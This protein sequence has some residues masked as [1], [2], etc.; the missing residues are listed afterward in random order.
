MRSMKRTN[1]LAA[2]LLVGA[3]VLVAG[4]CAQEVG[5]IDRTGPNK[6][7]KEDFQG[8]QWYF[9]QTV[10]DVPHTNAFFFTGL[11]TGSEKLRW[12]ITEDALIGY[13]SYE[14]TPGADPGAVTNDIDGT[15]VAEGHGEGINPDEYKGSPVVAYPISS[16]FDVQRAYNAQTGEQSNVLEENSSD[17]YWDER[18]YMRV[19]WAGNLLTNINF[20]DSDSLIQHQYFLGDEFADDD[21]AKPTINMEYGEDGKLNYL[22][23]RTKA[24]IV[25]S[26][27]CYFFY[28]ADCG[29]T[30]VEIVS[31]FKKAP[32]Q[33]TYEMVQYDDADMAKFGYFRT[34]RA[35]YDRRRGLRREG[36]IFLPN[37]HNIWE[38]AYDANGDLIPLAQRN[39]KTVVYY[40]NKHM[41]EDLWEYN[42]GTADSWD[43]AFR[44]AVAAA[45]GVDPD[46][47]QRMFAICHNPVKA[48]D[49]P[50]CG[51][52][53][54]EVATGDLRYNHVY[55]VPD[56]QLQGPLG[57]GPSAADPET[58][59]IISG[60]AYVYGAAVDRYAATAL[61]VVKLAIACETQVDGAGADVVKDPA[62]CQAMLDEIKVGDD[63]R[64]E[65]IGRVNSQI[66]PRS[67]LTAKHPELNLKALPTDAMEVFKP[68]QRIRYE[69]FKRNPMPYD[70]GFEKRRVDIVR[71]KGY[72]LMMFNQDDVRRLTGGQYDDIGQVPD[73][74]L[75]EI[76]PANWMTASKVRGLTE[77]RINHYARNNVLHEDFFDDV[78]I[79]LAL[80]L[81]NEAK[82]Q[83]EAQREDF[84]YQRLRG[85]IYKAVME[86][87]IGH[88]LG[89]R[90][91]FQGSYDSLN[92]FDE[93]WKL[94][95]ESLELVEAQHEA[96]ADGN[97]DAQASHEAW[98]EAGRPALWS[99]GDVY[100]L[101]A[102]TPNQ[103]A[104]RV[105]NA[106][107]SVEQLTGGMREYQY[108]SIMDY[109]LQFNT[110]IQGLGRYDEAAIIYAYTT[111][112]DGQMNDAG[113]PRVDKGYVEAFAPEAFAEA[114]L[115]DAGRP[116]V[117]DIIRDFDDRIS[118]AYTKL[119]EGYHYM[120]IADR[121]GNVENFS[122][123]ELVKYDVIK[124][125][126]AAG[127]INRPVEVPYMF[128]TDDWVGV[129]SSCHRWDHGADPYEQ[130]YLVAQ[131]YRNYYVFNNFSRDSLNFDPF[132]LVSRT[133]SRVLYYMNN[134][135]Q[136]VF[137]GG[138][139]NNQAF[140]YRWLGAHA[141]LNLVSEIMTMP[142]YGN[143][144]IPKAR[145][146]AT[147]L[148]PNSG[149]CEMGGYRVDV[150]VD[151][152]ND[153][154]LDSMELRDTFYVCSSEEIDLREQINDD[155]T[156]DGVGCALATV[157]N[158][159][160]DMANCQTGGIQIDYGTD[161]NG[162]GELGEDE[163]DVSSTTCNAEMLVQ[164]GWEADC[165]ESDVD[166]V[167]EKGEG[168][169][170][171]SRFDYDRGYNYYNYPTEAGHFYDYLAAVLSMTDTS[172][173]VRGVDVDTDLLSYS[174]P[175]HLLFSGEVNSLFNSLWLQDTQ[176]HGPR[177]VT[178]GANAGQ[179]VPRA[180]VNV[181]L[182][183]GLPMNPE[184]GEVVDSND[185]FA[186][187]MDNS[188]SLTVRP[189]VSYG[190]RFYALLYGMAFFSSNLDLTF[191]DNNK[192]FRVG[193]GEQ[194]QPGDG[195]NTISCED[196]ISG[197]TYAALTNTGS[198]NKS[199]AEIMVERCVMFADEYRTARARLDFN[200]LASVENDLVN[201]VGYMNLMR[202]FYSDFG[203]L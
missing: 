111:G 25:P 33:R 105:V 23:F 15:D 178:T 103:R 12:E 174:I 17:R 127:D 69:S 18:D 149:N 99:V 143:Y 160:A 4:G 167:I 196:P 20:F 106:D 77:A 187:G 108:S 53:G 81:A 124:E 3:S 146:V 97:D 134:I 198:L 29:P 176:K 202:S 32:E 135:Y 114:R 194:I 140:F 52:E 47:V 24:I 26:N 89:L 189:Y 107:G 83:P 79:G 163:I 57:Y 54:L 177:I 85:L 28:E 152:D 200:R 117:A 183:S 96:L 157:T 197:V 199:A 170:P 168:R 91:N 122:K 39:P 16:H 169:Y 70:P 7:K 179:L 136:G 130:S 95:K 144:T 37:R 195:F 64:M 151:V 10:A 161:L 92:Y 67:E 86:H 42:Q 116:E 2:C 73:D 40:L 62:G 201:V 13:R 186:P 58:G 44:R 184:T 22:E 76:R 56:P 98:V 141:G 84:M 80:S 193:A 118:P 43:V 102:E 125:G 11:S 128:C 101:V 180:L 166:Q 203:R 142:N 182:V 36:Q 31:S 45:K 123:R 148:R 145:V 30:E 50:A 109:G 165:A 87:E 164:C 104:G 46:S 173:T 100:N 74:L 68:E 175:F 61:D 120:D 5:D 181:E 72:D 153:E 66:D 192:I 171:Y 90:H 132:G 65:I 121:M 55:W 159:S 82:G 27:A 59:E 156:C 94:R 9:R 126:S 133:Y 6:L 63:V 150:G 88:T 139:F 78:V 162:D 34:E 19:D 71:E 8:G 93:Y 51:E 49:D 21:A 129:D 158:L 113:E 1:R 172:A 154:E 137:F 185:N 155:D 60:T 191:A 110:D 75:E 190:N 115:D 41:P 14:L 138:T 38:S 119:L 188:N 147:L 35:T 131:K 112:Y 48:S